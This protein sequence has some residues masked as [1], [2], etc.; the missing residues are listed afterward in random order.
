MSRR[1]PQSSHNAIQHPLLAAVAAYPDNWHFDVTSVQDDSGHVVS[2]HV[3]VI[4]KMTDSVLHSGS[5]PY[6]AGEKVADTV[7][8]WVQSNVSA[9]QA[10]QS[11]LAIVWQSSL[12]PQHRK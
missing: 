11:L 4:D 2:I 5:E 12:L 1:K 7:Q 9:L 3:S 10:L 8:R 6:T